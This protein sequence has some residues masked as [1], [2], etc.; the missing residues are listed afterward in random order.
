MR[1]TVVAITLLA[2]IGTTAACGS[3]SSST[4]KSTV[5]SGVETFS[6]TLVLT[7]A[8]AAS[9][10]FVP[11]IPLT[12][13]GV[14]HD[15]GSIYLAPGSGKDGSGPGPATIKLTKGDINVQHGASNPN[16]QPQ[17]MKAGTCLYGGKQ[18]VSFTI[19]GGT[20][21]YKNI[22]AGGKGTATVD[23]Q[24]TMPRMDHS[25][26]CNLADNAVPTGGTYIF[27]ATGTITR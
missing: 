26:E 16:L 6:G 14:I 25:K 1:T 12:A 18:N 17:L 22:K 13:T 23:E 5:T 27:T 11:T 8:E 4:V 24:F 20:G 7:P 21:A 10:S 19:T 3:S 2:A 15:T 9:Q